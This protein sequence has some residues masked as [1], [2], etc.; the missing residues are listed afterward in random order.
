[1]RKQVKAS[2]KT[3]CKKLHNAFSKK[4]NTQFNNHQKNTQKTKHQKP[5]N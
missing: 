3:M 2:I 4:V 1:M 5:K